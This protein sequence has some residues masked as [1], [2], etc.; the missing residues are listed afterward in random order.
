MLRFFLRRLLIIPF[1]LIVVN[2]LGFAFAHIT[3]QLQ[4]MQTVYGSG[5]EGITPVWPE[6]NAYVNRVIQ[7]DLGNMPASEVA[8]PIAESLGRASLASLGLVGIAFVLS[9]I[10]GLTL[11]LAAVRVDPPRTMQWLT[12]FSTV[13]LAVPS[14][15]IGTL[16]VSALVLGVLN[17]DMKAFLPVAGFGWDAHLIL[18][19]LALVIR[20]ATQVAQVT[21]NLLTSELN[22]RYVVAAR[23]FGHTWRAIRWDKALRNVLSPI[24]LTMA[25]SFRLLMAEL[26]LV[27]W[28][29]SWPGLGRLLV[30]TLVPPNLSSPGGYE[31]L[32]AYFLNPPL[33][34]GLLVIFSLL[35]LL[36]DLLASGAAKLIDPRLRM[37]EEEP[38]HD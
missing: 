5:K 20:P 31:N 18:P 30:L 23:S 9:V 14:F 17:Q 6:Y 4:Q 7:G 22:K 24:L 16:L 8:Q 2:F 29:F 32:S 11:G 27:E 1:A 36:A 15:Y 33:V 13:G 34:A 35:F 28:L 10:L 12:L 38:A 3:F 21:A 37:A 26:I 19:V 25:G